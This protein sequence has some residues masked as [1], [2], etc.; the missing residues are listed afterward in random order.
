MHV[1][2]GD[3]DQ[4]GC[5]PSPGQLHG[6]GI[7]SRTAGFGTYL[8]R[9]TLALRRFDQLVENHWIDVRPAADDRA[10]HQ[11]DR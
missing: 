4:T 5:Y 1:A 8:I 3:A 7:R 9:D 6:V 2:E 10:A 11:H